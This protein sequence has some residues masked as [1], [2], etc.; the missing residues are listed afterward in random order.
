MAKKD[1]KAAAQQAS[2]FVGLQ[3]KAQSTTAKQFS[4]TAFKKPNSDYYRLDLVVRDTVTNGK[5]KPK[6]VESIKVNYKE[7]LTIM[8]GYEGV[9]ITKYIQG[10]IDADMKKNKE[11]YNDLQNLK[12]S[13]KPVTL[14][15]QAEAYRLQQAEQLLKDMGYTEQADG[16]WKA[17]KETK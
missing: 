15:E 12:E 16:T 4:A 13:G 11:L 3:D 9:S 2:S 10:L 5:S 1:L 14:H 7:Y 8:S 17:P 6:M